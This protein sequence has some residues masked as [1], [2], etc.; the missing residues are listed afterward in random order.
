MEQVLV[1]LLIV[2]GVIFLALVW[3]YLR[4]MIDRTRGVGVRM[5]FI[6]GLFSMLGLLC[7]I[8][9][10]ANARILFHADQL[11]CAQRLEQLHTL[12][13]QCQVLNR[14]RYPEKLDQLRQVPDFR[15]AYLACPHTG[16]PYVYKVVQ[17]WPRGQATLVYEISDRVPHTSAD[18]WLNNQ[19]GRHRSFNGKVSW[20]EE[21]DLR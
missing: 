5:F 21:K 13:E 19:A 9:L 7:L 1:N 2:S 20:E 3:V 18:T 4:L 16:K 14:G 12:L 8:N 15:W 11:I 10:H 17:R 6:L